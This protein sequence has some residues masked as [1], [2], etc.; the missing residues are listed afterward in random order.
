MI[1]ELQPDKTNICKC[2]SREDSVQPK[3]KT[4]TI[5]RILALHK[6]KFGA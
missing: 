3:D 1:I 4:S 2:A 5:I 6:K